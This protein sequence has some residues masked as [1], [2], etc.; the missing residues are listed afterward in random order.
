MFKFFKKTKD[1]GENEPPKDPVCGMPANHVRNEASNGASDNITLKYKGRV[2][3]F[4]SDHCKQ[5]FEKEPEH[6]TAK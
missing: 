5:Q 1:T 4:C 2:Y 3:E 6:Y